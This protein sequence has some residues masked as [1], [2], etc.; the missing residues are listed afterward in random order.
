[1]QASQMCSIVMTLIAIA[2]NAFTK[3]L[4]YYSLEQNIP[5]LYLS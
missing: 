3:L 1:M 5:P 2:S 4:L